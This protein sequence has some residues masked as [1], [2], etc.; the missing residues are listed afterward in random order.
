MPH[1]LVDTRVWVRFHGNDLV[2][3]DL[4]ITAVGEH[5]PAEVAHHARSGPGTTTI[6]AEHY[7]PP[8]AAADAAGERAPRAGS[9]TEAEFLA[10]GPGATSLAG[11]SGWLGGG[12]GGARWPR[13]SRWPSCTRPARSSENHSLQ[14]GTTA[15][16]GFG[17]TAAPEPELGAGQA[18][19]D[20]AGDPS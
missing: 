13:L 6:Q 11:R 20:P 14:P 10:L 17:I 3:T 7:L 8:T 19:L 15:W 18:G 4:V 16:S 1:Q 2:I 12:G 5:G 9:A